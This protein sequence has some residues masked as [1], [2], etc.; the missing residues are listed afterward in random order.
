MKM[1]NTVAL[2]TLIVQFKNTVLPWQVSA[3]RG[4]VIEKVGREHILFNH[5]IDDTTYLYQYPLIQYKTVGGKGAIFC[6]GD[7]VDELYKLFHRRDWTIQLM[8]EKVA[9]EI[10]HLAIDS[11]NL[12]VWEKHYSYKL[13][14]WLPLNAENFKKYQGKNTEEEQTVFLKS[15]LIGN[16]LS[17]AK[18]VNWHIDKPVEV[19][20][21]SIESI[22]K[23]KYKQAN[24][25]SFTVQ[26][27]ANVFLPKFLGLG[28]AAS[29]GYGTLQQLK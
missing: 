17:F 3:F 29:H 9:L 8:Q 24:L 19:N 2:K 10:Q 16:I 7:G 13:Y 6:I 14:N 22:K 11:V 20:I 15:I 26:F 21:D 23:I 1:K 12:N 27:S 18:G 5:H 4:A 28:K 25:M